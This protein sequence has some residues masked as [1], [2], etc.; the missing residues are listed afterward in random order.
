MLGQA[1]FPG[2]FSLQEAFESSSLGEM[3]KTNS[4][5]LFSEEAS[6]LVGT[7]DLSL[8][9]HIM[10][11]YPETCPLKPAQRALNARLTQACVCEKA[12]ARLKAR[13]TSLQAQVYANLEKIPNIVKACCV[14]HNVALRDPDDVTFLKEELTQVS[15]DYSAFRDD[16][17]FVPTKPTDEAF[18]IRDAL[19]K[20]VD[21]AQHS[22][23]V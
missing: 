13:F 14:I 17:D 16:S 23:R 4:S 11:P 8:H 18:E 12:F 1:G 7:P 22:Q 21:D 15:E 9:K 20:I 19:A 3:I 10:V 2:T 5:F 6:Y